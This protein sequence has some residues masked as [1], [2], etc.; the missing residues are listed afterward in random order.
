VVIGGSAHDWS[1][2][3]RAEGFGQ[4]EAEAEQNL[5]SRSL[6]ISGTTLVLTGP[7]LYDRQH[8]TTGELVVEA[9]TDSGVVIHGSFASAEVRDMNGP[10]RIAAAH[11]RATV[12][13]TR[14]RVDVTAGCIDFAGTGG[15]ITLTAES[16]IN[17]KVSTGRFD[18]T[19]LAWAQRSVRLLIPPDFLTPLEITV[20]TR[21]RF[22]C[23]ADICP[24]MSYKLQGELHVFTYG[25]N[26]GD[27]ISAC[28]HLRSEHSTVVIDRGSAPG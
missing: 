17:L 20:S 10:V 18:G 26:L 28:L 2:F 16:E 9:P 19:L 14:G 1:V 8:D 23:R 7:G 27:S 25:M 11:A 24:K 12:L 5:R 4:T 22:V 3:L 6:E 13:D 21:D 15:Q